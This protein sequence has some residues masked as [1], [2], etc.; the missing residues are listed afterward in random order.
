MLGPSEDSVVRIQRIA[1]SR[2]AQCRWS[3]SDILMLLEQTSTAR[4]PP[5]RGSRMSDSPNTAQHSTIALAQD[6]FRRRGASK[7]C[8]LV[9]MCIAKDRLGRVL[10]SETL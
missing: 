3:D 10:G 2:I 5:A 1:M 7:S 6:R 4:E 8:I 9:A